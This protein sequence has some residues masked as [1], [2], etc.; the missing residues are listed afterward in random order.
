MPHMHPGARCTCRDV[1]A[2]LRD[3]NHPV[4][5]SFQDANHPVVESLQDAN[6]IGIYRPVPADLMLVP[7]T[8]ADRLLVTVACGGQYETLLREFTG[9]AMQA[10]AARIRADFLPLVGRTQDWW[11]LEKFRVGAVAQRYQRTLFVD[12]DVLIRADAPDIFDLVPE[13]HIAMHDDW[14]AQ[15]DHQWHRAQ[16]D[17]LWSSQGVPPLHLSTMRNS[18]V[19]VCDQM[20]ADIW[21][22]PERPV[23][24]NHCDEQ[25]WVE[26]HARFYPSFDLPRAWNTQW[27]YPD[28][29]TT[30]ADAYFV[31]FAC[32]PME[33]RLQEICRE[34]LRGNTVIAAR[35]ASATVQQRQS[36][37]EFTASPIVTPYPDVP[38]RI[39]RDRS[40]WSSPV[41]LAELRR[42]SR[43]LQPGQ[44]I[45]EL[46][47][48]LGAVSTQALLDNPRIDLIC[49]DQF[50]VDPDCVPP[51]A[52][53][54][55]ESPFFQRQGT[56]WEHFVNNT[57]GDRHRV[58]PITG[59]AGPLLLRQLWETG[60]DVQLVLVDADHSES[61][62]YDELFAITTLWPHATIALDDHVSDWPG[63]SAALSRAREAG[64]FRATDQFTLVDGR[65]MVI[66]RHL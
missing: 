56:Q 37:S 57:F 53:P 50:D 43:S 40:G 30:R 29:P 60:L 44:V 5:A 19:I 28:F 47:S 48:F 8:P 54:L 15:G 66:D 24:G 27:Y 12:A 10:Y 3:A 21:T 33:L 6:N 62:V 22:P 32:C 61:A 1:G 36:W 64:M 49:V 25:F 26:R 14:A 2:Y 35:Q 23:P 63:V 51:A 45:L 31:H 7:R 65:L 55:G 58:A 34:L 42:L 16:R 4:V 52:R 41:I 59:N 11:G 39:P 20:H 18:G 46:G 17:A 38:Y 13:G 9:P